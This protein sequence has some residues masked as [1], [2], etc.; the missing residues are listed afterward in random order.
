M[1]AFIYSIGGLIKRIIKAVG[2]KR[3]GL[4]IYQRGVF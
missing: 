4:T 3:A 1:E 2:K